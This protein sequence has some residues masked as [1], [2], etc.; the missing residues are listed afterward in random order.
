MYASALF[1]TFASNNEIG[2]AYHASLGRLGQLQLAIMAGFFLAV[3]WAGGFSDRHGKIPA[4]FGG[5]VFLTAGSVLFAQTGSFS[6]A[7]LAALLM[8][9]GGGLSEGSAMALIA[10]LYSDSARTA[11]MNLSQAA[12]TVG[13]VGA[14]LAVGGLLKAGLS[15]RLGYAGTAAMCMLCAVLAAVAWAMRREVIAGAHEQQSNWR[16]MISRRLVVWLALGIMLYVG[17]E[18]GQSSWLAVYFERG[19]DAKKSLAASSLAFLW[20]GL[21]LGRIAAAWVSRYMTE[22]PL[23]AWALG[24]AAVCEAVLIL[25]QEPVLG[26]AA[27]FGLGVFLGPVFPTIV[28]CAGAAYPRQS[29]TVTAIVVAA[30]SLGGAIFPPGIGW[31]A[32]SIGLR[33]ALWTCCAILL[34]NMGIFVSLGRRKKTTSG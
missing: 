29:G 26:L 33:T 11:M 12:F 21:G 27:A 13:A 18:L 5:A 4:I 23:I 15:W 10:D 9:I 6:V 7:L 25:A 31:A 1:V 14:P 17:A 8:G 20:L 32:D 30:G 34:V 16:E 2:R 3:L 24:L 22:M 19:L 28:S